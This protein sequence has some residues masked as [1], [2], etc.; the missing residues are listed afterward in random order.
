MILPVKNGDERGVIRLQYVVDAM[1]L[2]RTKKDEIDGKPLV[3]LPKKTI[4]LKELDFTSEERTIYDAYEGNAKKIIEK[5]MKK[6]TLLRNYA[7]VFAIMMRLRQLCCH[8]EL[9]P[10]EWNNLDIN[11]I[12]E[13]V[14]REAE[15]EM[16]DEDKENAKKLAE[17]LR[18]L[19][20]GG[21]SDECSICLSDMD[22]PVI[23]PCAHVYC[24]LCIVQYI[25]S[26]NPPGQAACPLC[27]GPLEKKGLL[28]AAI[29]EENEN[30]TEKNPED[31]AVNSDSTK[32]DAAMEKLMEIR[33]NS[34]EDKTIIVSQFTSLLSILQP[35]LKEHGFKFTRLD[36]SM[37]VKQ[38]SKVISKFQEEDAD[39][40]MVMLLSLRAGEL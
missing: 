13:M 39:S 4:I 38:K 24:R 32:V 31:V 33:K 16:D 37:S 8:R 17:Q 6:G 27:R 26:G 12:V 34:P 22:H 23:T 5:Y 1:M 19:I 40:P 28:E 36:G 9:L 7:H 2:R 18:D 10:L 3:K 30:A 11:E 35:L 14:K 25:D 21:M 15:Q 29:D 20:K